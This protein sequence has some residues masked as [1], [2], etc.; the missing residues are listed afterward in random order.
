[1]WDCWLAGASSIDDK[2]AINDAVY[3]ASQM[4]FSNEPS[5]LVDACVQAVRFGSR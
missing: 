2:D 5:S 3:G 1:M 4:G